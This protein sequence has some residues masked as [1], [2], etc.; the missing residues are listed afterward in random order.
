MPAKKKKPSLAKFVADNPP[1]M[2]RSKSFFAGLP[3][4][5]R[6]QL[7]AGKLK[8]YTVPYMVRWLHSE[9]YDDATRGKL[10][11]HLREA[12]AVAANEKS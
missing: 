6:K 5:V 10:A 3:A 11:D 1:T 12:A 2:S 7:I 8:G 4:D 9:G